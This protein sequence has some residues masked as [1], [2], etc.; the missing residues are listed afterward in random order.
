M[1]MLTSSFPSKIILLRFHIC[2]MKSLPEFVTFLQHEPC[3]LRILLILHR[4]YIG[5][6]NPHRIRFSSSVL[7]NLLLKRIGNIF[8]VG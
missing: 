4:D 1:L 3:G 5:F 6:E 7:I 8:A 2:K